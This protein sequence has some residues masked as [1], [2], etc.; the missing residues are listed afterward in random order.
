MT[1]RKT[2]AKAMTVGTFRLAR[3]PDWPDTLHKAA[4]RYEQAN[5]VAGNART[6]DAFNAALDELRAAERAYGVQC[7]AL[8][9]QRRPEFYASGAQ[10]NARE[11]S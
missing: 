11:A 4:D 7:L 10:L 6:A 8:D 9:K 5:L 3:V 2:D 1:A